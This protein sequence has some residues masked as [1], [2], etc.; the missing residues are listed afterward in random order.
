MSRDYKSTG[1]ITSRIILNKIFV[2][3]RWRNE[4]WKW[5]LI[6]SL[7]GGRE[8]RREGG[9]S[10]R[11]EAWRATAT[12]TRTIAHAGCDRVGRGAFGSLTRGNSTIALYVASS[13]NAR[14]NKEFLCLLRNVATVEWVTV[15]RLQ[16]ARDRNNFLLVANYVTGFSLLL[17]LS[18]SRCYTVGII[19]SWY[20]SIGK[21]LLF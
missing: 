9:T 6:E 5:I 8:G 20:C 17:R 11:E 21:I 14:R 7:R 15:T 4:P 3:A 13:I 19:V 12:S 10:G 18:L 1:K 16:S 2:T